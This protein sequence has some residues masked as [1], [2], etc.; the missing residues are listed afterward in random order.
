MMNEKGISVPPYRQGD[1][2]AP[3]EEK[4]LALRVSE[5]AAAFLLVPLS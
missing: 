1:D 4:A 5:I 2:V 3:L